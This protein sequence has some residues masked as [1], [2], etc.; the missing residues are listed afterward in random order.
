[1]IY[2]IHVNNHLIMSNCGNSQRYRVNHC[3]SD[4]T[5]DTGQWSCSTMTKTGTNGYNY[6]KYM[7]NAH[8]SK[9]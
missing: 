1:M 2:D 9:N 3:L 5:K 4:L 8:F 6:E 7:Y